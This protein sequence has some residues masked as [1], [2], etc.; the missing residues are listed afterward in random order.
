MK[1]YNGNLVTSFLSASV[2]GFD[3]VIESEASSASNS[4][5]DS[6]INS[7]YNFESSTSFYQ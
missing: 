1:N 3:L 4:I 5:F 7:N 2:G 6:N